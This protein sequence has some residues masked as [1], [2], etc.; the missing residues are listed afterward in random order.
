M[1]ASICTCRRCGKRMYFVPPSHMVRRHGEPAVEDDICNS[2][3]S[4]Q[5]QRDSFL[6]DK[7]AK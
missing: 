4:Q 1:G 7:A 6:R 2:C 5:Y 3:K